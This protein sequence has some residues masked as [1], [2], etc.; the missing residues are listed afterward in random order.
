MGN[1]FDLDKH[2][3][4]QARRL[5][6][7]RLRAIVTQ[8]AGASL[9]RS[10]FSCSARSRLADRTLKLAHPVSHARATLCL[11]SFV[12]MQWQGERPGPSGAG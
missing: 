1:P 12:A 5:A 7:G 2:L 11:M 8:F 3:S 6:P 9:D 10:S 4:D